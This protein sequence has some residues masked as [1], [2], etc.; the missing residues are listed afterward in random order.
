MLPI[1]IAYIFVGLIVGALGRQTAAGFGGTFLLSL[2]ISPILT[3]LF[4]MLMRPNKRDRL[5]LMQVRLDE[6]YQD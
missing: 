1:I 6:K 3:L 4:L 5:S 2:I